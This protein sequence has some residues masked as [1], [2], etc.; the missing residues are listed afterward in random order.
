MT[1][2][3]RPAPR[4][5]ANKEEISGVAWKEAGY[6]DGQPLFAPS[7]TMTPEQRRVAL[8]LTI[9]AD[10][11]AV[12]ANHARDTGKYLASAS[13]FR[14]ALRVCPN[15][16]YLLTGLGA[17]QWFCGD[18][19]G[20]QATLAKSLK[21]NPMCADANRNMGSVL[22]SM[23]YILEAK[24]FFMKSMEIDPSNDLTR[25]NYAM[26]LLDHGEWTADAWK[27]FDV[28]R[29]Y[30]GGS[31]KFPTLPYPMWNGEDL[32][33]KILYVRGEQGFGDRL[34]F[35]RYLAWISQKWPRCRIIT[36]MSSPPMPDMRSLLWEFRHFIEF[37]PPG[38]PMPEADYG[39]FLMSLPGIAGD[40]P[41]KVFPD[42]GLIR[43]AIL[44]YAAGVELPPP[45]ERDALKIG[46]C[47]QGN[48]LMIRN[49]DRSVPFDQMM[50][51]FEIP[52]ACFYG[53][54]FGPAAADIE[55]FGARDL[56]F[57]LSADIENNG[58]GFVGTGAVMLNLDL[59]I[60]TCTANAHL[61]GALGVPCWVILGADP[62]WIWGRGG[63]RACAWYPNT[64]IF[65]QR[66][67]GDWSQVVEWVRTELIGLLR[68][69][70]AAKVG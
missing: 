26:A 70:A 12:A 60:T 66:K 20:A 16:A 27:M 65:R 39:V 40:Q 2:D 14:R 28:R 49:N 15:N 32:D 37:L 63:A 33:G 58:M 22:S 69:R 50:P 3:L 61:A 57:D 38:V 53:L 68:Q 41:N 23:G 36:M 47:W 56:C 29:T 13:L 25:W 10:R 21:I 8:S 42:P 46:V 35:S 64:R 31:A 67:P 1:M 7:G 43:R 17:A 34:L 45:L 6:I 44:P 59:V 19:E 9:M 62:Y 4:P 55:R 51:L 24:Q 54:Q 18:F 30:I 5:P 48:P 52:D 11:L